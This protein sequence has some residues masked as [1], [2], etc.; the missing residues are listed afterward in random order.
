MGVHKNKILLVDD[1]QIIRNS[2]SRVLREYDISSASSGE[3]AVQVS[4]KNRYDLAIVDIIMPGIGGIKTISRL[5]KI[6]KNMIIIAMTAHGT[7]EGAVEAMKA[8][9]FHYLTMTKPFDIEET[10]SLVKKA[11]SSRLMERENSNKIVDLSRVDRE[12]IWRSKCME[13]VFELIDRVSD[14]DSTV[15]ITGESGTGKELIARAIHNLSSRKKKRMIAVNCGAIPG[16]LLESELFGHIKG[17]FTGAIAPRV[18]RFELADEGTVFLDE[19]G[20][21]SHNLQAKILRVLQ[22]RSFEPIG[23]SETKE[24][25]VRVIAATHCDLEKSVKEGGFREDL[26]YRINV[27]PISLPPLRERREDVLPLTQHFIEKFNKRQNRDISGVNESA[28]NLLM[29]YPW[30]G[31]VRELENLIERIVILKGSGEIMPSDLPERYH[32]A[33]TIPGRGVYPRIILSDEGVNFNSIISDFEDDL[34]VQALNRTNWNKK[35]AADLLGLNR[36]TL[37]EKV[38]KKCIS[39]PATA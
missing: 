34:I 10:L 4:K 5:K 12:I 14:T 20:D 2:L 6:N 11:L 30:P 9:A 38:K 17:A 36:T 7:V 23:S 24:V 32:S 35:H 16:E 37:V 19:I 1:E 31:N 26:F 29:N 22:E 18:G 13:K 33:S 28:L 21:M 27:I 39:K 3:Q 8:G 15:L 25:D